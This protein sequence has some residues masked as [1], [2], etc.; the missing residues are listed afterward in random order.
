MP[1][2]NRIEPGDLE[3]REFHLSL[4]ACSAI[5]VLAGGLALLMYPAVFATKE[6]SSSRI[7]QVA[8]F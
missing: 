1:T 4:F 6:N 8:F 7:P 3:R 2:N 5:V